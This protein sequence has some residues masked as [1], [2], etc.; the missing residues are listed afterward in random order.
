MY[1]TVQIVG[2]LLILAAFVGSVTGRFAQTGTGY[3][4]ANAV[5]SAVLT[6]T[7]VISR[8]W[9]FLLLEGVWAFV[10]LARLLQASRRN[11]RD[12]GRIVPDFQ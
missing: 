11:R 12:A 1:D 3:L 4:L 7:A 5:G 10:S 8:E 2:S 9:G 6:V